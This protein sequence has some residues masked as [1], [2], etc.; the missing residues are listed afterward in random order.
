MD[1]GLAGNQ[2]CYEAN[3]NVE[4]GTW[5]ELINDVI[6]RIGHMFSGASFM[7]TSIGEDAWCV[8]DYSFK[9]SDRQFYCMN[10]GCK[11]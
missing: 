5:W 8:L 11:W 4:D 6:A 3:T 1:V 10:E 2:T 7:I 9:Y